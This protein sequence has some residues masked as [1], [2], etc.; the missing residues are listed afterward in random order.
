MPYGYTP[1][2]WGTSGPVSGPHGGG[3]GNR[4]PTER[5]WEDRRDEPT[6][7]VDYTPPVDTSLSLIH[8]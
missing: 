6:V 3:G 8:I 1:P 7:R 2:A 4:P 5:V